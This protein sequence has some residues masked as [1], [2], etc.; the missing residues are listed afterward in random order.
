MSGADDRPAVAARILVVEDNPLNLEL[1]T[2]M[3]SDEGYLV[4]QAE[5]ETTALRLAREEGPDLILMDIQLPGADGLEI[6]R[7][8]RA[9]PATGGIP[10]VALTAHAMR[11]EEEKAR[12]AGCVGFLTKP[13]RMQDLLQAVAQWTRTGGD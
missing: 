7:K 10:I 11:G 6:T 2:D 3:L 12:D 9:D 8:L 1:V 4:L 13:L 5:D